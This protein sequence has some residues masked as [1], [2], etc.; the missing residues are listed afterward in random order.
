MTVR[1]TVSKHIVLIIRGMALGRC[2]CHNV[3]RVRRQPLV[4][5]TLWSSASRGKGR[6]PETNHTWFISLRT[7]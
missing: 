6:T 7:C 2:W 3:R 1:G 4:V 5:S